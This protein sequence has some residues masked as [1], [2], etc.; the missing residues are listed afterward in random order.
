APNDDV[1]AKRIDVGFR[2]ESPRLVIGVVGD[3]RQDELIGDSLAIYQPFTQVSRVWQMGSLNFLVQTIGNPEAQIQDLR[4]ALQDV[5]SDLPAYDVMPM[6]RAVSEKVSDPRFYAALLGAFSVIAMALAA[7]GIYG[8]TSFSVARRTHEI[9][10]RIALGAR[11]ADILG[12]ILLKGLIC[13]GSGI[14][15]GLLAA[16]GLTRLLKDF[17]YGVT[18]SDPFTF[19]AISILLAVTALLASYTPARK[20]LAVDP[21]IAL[22]QE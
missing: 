20:A 18:P 17:L 6:A 13:S 14:L 1:L 11:G 5:D 21:I 19:V 12:T 7:A 22:R 16:F 10:I 8:L 4:T 2:G 15:L 9:G 3:T